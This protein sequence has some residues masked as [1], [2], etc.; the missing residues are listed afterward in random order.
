MTATDCM[1]VATPDLYDALRG[2]PEMP[3]CI[4]PLSWLKSMIDECLERGPSADCE[5]PDAW[6]MMVCEVKELHRKG[7]AAVARAEGRP[8]G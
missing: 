5:D 2:D 4:S 6:W 8:N 1:S 7:T 3:E